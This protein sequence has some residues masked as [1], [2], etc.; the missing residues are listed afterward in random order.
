MAENYADAKFTLREC[1]S[2]EPTNL[3]RG[4]ALNSLALASW[5]HKHPN[6]RDFGNDDEEDDEFGSSSF[7]SKE[8]IDEDFAD[9]IPLFRKAI[10]YIGNG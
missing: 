5:W 9:V 6:L 8:K 1:L 2:Q 7:Y 10:Y 4:W 3:L